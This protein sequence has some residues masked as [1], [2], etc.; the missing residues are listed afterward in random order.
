MRLPPS[1]LVALSEPTGAPAPFDLNTDEDIL[2]QA[3]Q[4]PEFFDAVDNDSVKRLDPSPTTKKTLPNFTVSFS[5]TKLRMNFNKDCQGRCLFVAEM[6]QTHVFFCR[7]P[8][9]GSKTTATIADARMKDPGKTLYHQIIGLHSSS[10]KSIMQMSFESFPRD[11]IDNFDGDRNY[12]NMM[13]L[14]FSE[15]KFVYLH[16]L[17]LEI[18]DYFFEGM[19]GSAVWGS[20]PK[21]SPNFFDPLQM[22]RAFK[23][24]R[25]AIK[26]E[27]PLL[28]L[29]VSYR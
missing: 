2:Q 11:A 20:K 5:L 14:D 6:N 15:M 19:L 25:L 27:Q 29:P 21:A 9:G 12:D 3:S 23:R 24:T 4:Y 10:S 22:T 18:F 7:K 16:Q 26:M 1:E 28:L 13:K 8:L 17:W